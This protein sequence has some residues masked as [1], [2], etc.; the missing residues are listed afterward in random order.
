MG[1]IRIYELARELN[2]TNT[3]LV[4]RLH[5]I[6]YPV[7]SHM[8]S[9]EESELPE[10]KAKLSGKKK[11]VKLEEKRIKPTVI[12]RRRVKTIKEP[13]VVAEPSTPEPVAE[14]APPAAVEETKAEPV[15][16]EE[17][18]QETVVEAP[19]I[20]LGFIAF[21]KGWPIGSGKC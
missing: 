2:M 18:P 8:S 14:E 19:V 10:L 1:K 11:K 9:I 7:K 13:E 5:E 20:R 15:L 16:T 21:E 17:T 6:G 3:E 12:R 4:D